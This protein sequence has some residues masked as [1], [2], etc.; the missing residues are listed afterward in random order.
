MG[1]RQRIAQDW[2]LLAAGHNLA[3]MAVRGVHKTASG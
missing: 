2:Q 3:R 1:G